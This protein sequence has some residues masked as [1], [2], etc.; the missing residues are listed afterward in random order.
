VQLHLADIGGPLPDVTDEEL[1]PYWNF[2][3][4]RRLA[5]PR[6]TSCG[7][8]VWPPRGACRRCRNLKFVWTDI[9]TSGELFTWTTVWQTT[10]VGFHDQVPYVVGVVAITGTNVRMTGLVSAA[11]EDVYMGMPV[12]CEFQNASRDQ[13]GPVMPIWVVAPDA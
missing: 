1:A 12:S 6:C 3:R 7:L 11:P 10:L 2:L 8:L 5:V 4:E 13:A 9:P